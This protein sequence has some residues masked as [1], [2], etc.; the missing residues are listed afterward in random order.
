M[1]SVCFTKTTSASC[2]SFSP[3][4]RL[5]RVRTFAGLVSWRAAR[6]FQ[7]STTERGCVVPD[8]PQRARLGWARGDR[9]GASVVSN[10]VRQ[11]PPGGTQRRSGEPVSFFRFA[12]LTAPRYA[13]DI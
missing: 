9:A 2:G 7:F 4:F 3:V 12:S 5:G 8:Q 1:I 11:I 10:V 6:V 13:R